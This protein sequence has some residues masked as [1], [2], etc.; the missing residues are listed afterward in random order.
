MK[1]RKTC[2]EGNIKRNCENLQISPEHD[3]I[4]MMT[5]KDINY[6]LLFS[7]VQCIVQNHAEQWLHR[8]EVL[9]LLS[10]KRNK[11][12]IFTELPSG[13]VCLTGK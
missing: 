3:N 1:I 7:D 4:S 6:Y 11:E 8:Q 13:K 2:R 5:V 9:G 10:T 12:A